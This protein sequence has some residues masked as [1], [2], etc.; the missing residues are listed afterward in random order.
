MRPG[1]GRDEIHRG[2]FPV[3]GRH[4]FQFILFFLNIIFSREAVR[5]G[6]LSSVANC[7]CTTPRHKAEKPGQEPLLVP[8]VGQFSPRSP[9]ELHTRDDL[10]NICD[11]EEALASTSTEVK[12][13]KNCD[14][15]Y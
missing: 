7:V 15:S 4:K 3:Q 10:Q 6:G 12:Q 9:L 5:D 1:Q 11:G 2:V 8:L 13:S 14:R